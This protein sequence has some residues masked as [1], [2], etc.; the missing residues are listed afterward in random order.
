[1]LS[2]LGGAAVLCFILSAV[3][4]YAGAGDAY[5]ATLDSGPFAAIGVFALAFGVIAYKKRRRLESGTTAFVVIGMAIGAFLGWTLIA[6]LNVWLDR[7][8]AEPLEGEVVDVRTESRSRNPPELV[9][10]LGGARLAG[11]DV[12]APACKDG[13]HIVLQVRRGAPSARDAK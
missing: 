4:W 11:R 1:M 8:A 6:G 12:L 13:Q 10:L 2:G 7:S 9:V 5:L 3:L